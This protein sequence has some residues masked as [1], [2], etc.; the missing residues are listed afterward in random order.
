MSL[1]SCE[2]T[3]D[4]IKGN[5]VLQRNNVSPNA[6]YLWGNHS[7]KFPKSMYFGGHLIHVSN[8]A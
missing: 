8:A 1:S 7:E 2:K 5:Q 3:V 4:L 6:S